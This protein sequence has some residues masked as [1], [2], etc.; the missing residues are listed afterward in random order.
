MSDP[1][2]TGSNQDDNNEID[3]GFHLSQYLA[4]PKA[5][6]DNKDDSP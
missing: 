2:A 3:G 4:A 5:I 6:Q 1:T